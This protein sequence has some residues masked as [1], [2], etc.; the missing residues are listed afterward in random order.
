MPTLPTRNAIDARPNP[1]TLPMPTAASQP[2]FSPVS[3][4]GTPDA[5]ANGSVTINPTSMIH[6]TT[7]HGLMIL[8]TREDTSEFD[9]NISAAPSPQTI[10]ITLGM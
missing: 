5:N 2:M 6:A 8:T 9:A 10:L 4:S 3:S 7:D 1:M